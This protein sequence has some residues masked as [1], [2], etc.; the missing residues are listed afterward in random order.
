[1]DVVYQLEEEMVDHFS[2]ML[3]IAAMAK[4]FLGQN[5]YDGICDR[6]RVRLEEAIVSL[7]EW[8]GVDLSSRMV[9]CWCLVSG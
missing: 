6:V 2:V 7:V 1:M 5:L 8:S 9:H 3:R 4:L